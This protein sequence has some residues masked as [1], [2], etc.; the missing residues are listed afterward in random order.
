M[1]TRAP[2]ASAEDQ[3]AQAESENAQ[4]ES[5][6]IETDKEAVAKL[7][8]AQKRLYYLNRNELMELFA[9]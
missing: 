8:S 6:D 5:D 4:A 1:G 7:F 2:S 9:C 3:A